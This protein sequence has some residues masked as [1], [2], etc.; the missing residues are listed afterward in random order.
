V[1]D[2]VLRDAS[3]HVSDILRFDDPGPNFTPGSPQLIF[4]YSNDHGGLMGDTGLPSMML[5]NTV[6]I[7]EAPSGPTIYTPGLG[8]PGR[9]TD[10]SL[11]N[12]FLI[13]STPDTGS[14]LLM[15]GAAIA[16][17]VFLRWK[18]VAV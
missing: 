4:F 15:L 1:G 13:F 9:S 2:V 10:S 8:Q 11:G 18:M 7:Q 14:T 12:S 3:G 16:G 17:L 6:T 5:P